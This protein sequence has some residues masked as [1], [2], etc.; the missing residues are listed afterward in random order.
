LISWIARGV[1]WWIGN[2][3][4]TMGQLLNCSVVSLSCQRRPS[5]ET[6]MKTCSSQLWFHGLASGK[7]VHKILDRLWFADRPRLYHILNKNWHVHSLTKLIIV[8]FLIYQNSIFELSSMNL[9]TLSYHSRRSLI[10][11]K[12]STI[13]SGIEFTSM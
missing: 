12:V 7:S 5:W 6:E 1:K 2:V 8:M 9:R 13:E 3:A 11:W 4:E 10:D